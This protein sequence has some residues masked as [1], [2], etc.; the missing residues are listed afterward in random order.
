MLFSL[1]FLTISLTF[2]Y[3]NRNLS[4][5]KY[6]RIQFESNNTTLYANLYYPSKSLSFQGKHPLII[7]AHGLGSQRDLDLRI[8]IE[9][10]KRGFFVATIDYQG[11]GESGGHLMD[12]DEKTNR[13]AIAEVCSNLLDTI[14]QMDVYKYHIN[15]SQIGLFGYSFGGMITLITNT[16]DTRF[17]ATVTWSAPAYIDLSPLNIPNNHAFYDIM[18]INLLNQTNSENL[19]IIHH[20]NDEVVSYNQNALIIQNLTKCQLITI[21]DPLFGSGHGMLSDYALQ[22]T[23][24]WYEAKFF[25]S[26]TINGEVNL[27]Y[28]INYLLLILSLCALFMTIF[29]LMYFLSKYFLI[30]KEKFPDECDTEVSIIRSIPKSEKLKQWLKVLLISIIYVSIW[31]FFKKYFGLLNGLLFAPIIIILAF[32]IIKL[33]YLVGWLKVKR[34]IFKLKHQLL[35]QCE[36]YVLAYS[37][38]STGVFLL[39]YLLFS[40]S[41]PFAFFFPTNIIGYVLTFSIYPFYLAI[42]IFYR[43]ILYP[44][45][46]FII[47]PEIKSIAI[48]ILII[49]NQLIIIYILRDYFLISALAATLLISLVVAILNSIIY[50]K[51]NRMSS[52]LISSFIIIQLFFG[53]AFST[54]LGMGSILFLFLKF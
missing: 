43:K 14:E 53:A 7:S 19:L 31:I 45:L 16:L 41:Y 12:I 9:L 48:I 39:F 23:I 11:H 49:C 4:Y 15:N 21:T 36:K 27:S 3:I 6:D 34:D 54:V 13:P 51:T 35:C 1:L 28:L 20:V 29:S 24:N 33:K 25:N 42:E 2:L 10:T 52:V 17:K 38:F 37:F 47:S 32:L 18:P 44:M 26:R 46:Y 50:E 30:Y 22:T 5:Y 40:I 8:P